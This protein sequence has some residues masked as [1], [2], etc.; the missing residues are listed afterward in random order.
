MDVEDQDGGGYLP[1]AKPGVERVIT[2]LFVACLGVSALITVGSGAIAFLPIAPAVFLFVSLFTVFAAV[3]G[4][5]PLYLIARLTGWAN[6]WTAASAGLLTGMLASAV[7]QGG[8]SSF[9]ATLL[10]GGA[11]VV[12]G[13]L[14][15]LALMGSERPAPRALARAG[16]SNKRA[17]ALLAVITTVA[18]PFVASQAFWLTRDQSCHNWARDGRTSISPAAG[19]N[20]QVTMQDWP[21]IQQTLATFARERGWSVREDVRIDPGFPWFQISMCR[22]PGIHILANVI[23]EW[24]KVY[25]SIYDS[26]GSGEWRGEVAELRARFEALWPGQLQ[27]ESDR[28]Q[29][30]DGNVSAPTLGPAP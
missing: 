29:S 24:G 26:G 16:L 18:S 5:V 22:E 28:A 8:N 27:G 20:F 25:I 17:A 9:V 15:W 10:F 30:S 3:I 21:I 1:A 13:L 11:G 7:L 19:F 14:F 4:A 12:G 6:I 23:D 2:A